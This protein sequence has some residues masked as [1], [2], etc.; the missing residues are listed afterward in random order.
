MNIL[1][2]FD[3]YVAQGFKI[4]PL[5]PDTKKPIP[6][7]W[8]TRWNEDHMRYI[9]GKVP[10]CNMGFVLGNIMDVEGDTPAANELLMRITKNCSHP[11]Y[12]ST[13][14]I[15]HLFLNPDPSMG[16]LKYEGIEFRGKNC[17]SVLPPSRFE[18][19]Q[20]LWH[21][22]SSFPIPKMPTSVLDLLKTARDGEKKP[23]S[24]KVFCSC[25]QQEYTLHYKRLALEVKAF[26]ILEQ[27]WQC[28]Q[29]RDVDVRPLC[30]EI[31]KKGL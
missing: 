12:S 3:N 30:C 22:E 13:R 5:R 28:R 6:Y 25:C 21:S 14:S 16:I 29:C 7:N 2:W 9:F 17:Q 24:K 11:M 27:K 18:G 19:K 8:N 15:H 1:A 4:I 31:R 23:G 10:Q 20:Y 26:K